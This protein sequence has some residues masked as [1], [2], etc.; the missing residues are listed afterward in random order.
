MALKEVQ[1]ERK[2]K[3]FFSPETKATA[4][5]AKQEKLN[6]RL[7]VVTYQE[8]K[9]PCLIADFLFSNTLN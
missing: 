2:K 5:I 6:D 1:K 4:M 9:L 3:C 8:I 7:S